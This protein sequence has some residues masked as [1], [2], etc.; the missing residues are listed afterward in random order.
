MDKT[1]SPIKRRTLERRE[2]PR[3]PDNTVTMAPV[4]VTA[5]GKSNPPVHEQRRI[6]LSGG[7]PEWRSS[8]PFTPKEFDRLMETYNEPAPT[9]GHYIKIGCRGLVL[10]VLGLLVMGVLPLGLAF[11]LVW[12]HI[13]IVE[14]FL[15]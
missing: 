3:S 2:L 5:P 11:I 9:I 8:L 7:E 10:G 4:P 15:D 6:H 12:M 1:P 13:L 14:R